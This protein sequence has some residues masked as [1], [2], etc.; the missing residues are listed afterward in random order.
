M[1]AELLVEEVD[2]EI[3]RL[4]ADA[5]IKNHVIAAM[6]VAL[7]PSFFIE[8]SGVTGIEVSLI[9]DLANIYGFPIPNRLIAYKILLSLILT[10]GPL[11]LIIRLRPAIKMVP[12]AGQAAYFG[13]VS[14]TNAATVYAIG[15]IF[16]LHF[17]SGGKL[18]SKDNS[19]LRRIFKQQYE[20]GKQRITE[21]KTERDLAASQAT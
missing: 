7:V 21:Y 3:E 14:F 16:Q 4:K 10:L 1:V 13:L 17:E 11:Y 6:G 15:K 5:C 12:V 9:M 19:V 18:L 8:L 2:W 20:N